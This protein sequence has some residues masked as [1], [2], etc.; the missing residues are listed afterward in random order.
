MPTIKRPSRVDATLVK[1]FEEAIAGRGDGRVSAS[2]VKELIAPAFR[3]S[4]GANWQGEEP[5][6]LTETEKA[7]LTWAMT[8]FKLTG[9]ARRVL[10]EEL[11]ALTGGPV[12]EWQRN[13]N[14][15]TDVR[16]G[17]ELTQKELDTRAAASF[18]ANTR[19]F[20]WEWGDAVFA[21]PESGNSGTH[22]SALSGDDAARQVLFMAAVNN[23]PTINDRFSPDT[24]AI[25]SVYESDDEEHFGAIFVDK[26]TGEATP[27][28]AYNIVD[29]TYD[30][31][32]AQFEEVFGKAIRDDGTPVSDDDFEDWTYDADI[33]DKIPGRDGR[34]VALDNFSAA[35]EARRDGPLRDAFRPLYDA[36]KAADGPREGAY[37]IGT[38]GKVGD[39]DERMSGVIEAIHMADWRDREVDGS[40]VNVLKPFGKVD[41]DAR[42]GMAA[43]V[44][45]VVGQGGKAMVDDILA[46]LGQRRDLKVA[47]IEV[48]VA[49]R[50]PDTRQYTEQQTVNAHVVINTE[51]GD[52]F[53][54]YDRARL[55]D[56]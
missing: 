20:A 40:D 55:A 38:L 5:G 15:P 13:V 21:H 45:A 52:W 32:R 7:T 39:L 28:E 47:E 8:A 17:G 33:W 46:N 31:S 29:L 49:L 22:L 6:R 35:Q 50:D 3:D 37:D 36:F 10:S 27:V 51:E 48:D 12:F 1:R 34:P 23:D 41:A 14:G 43:T 4:W 42:A 24:H 18:A 2:D 11:I 9:A 26:K 19:A 56:D 53:V 30:L 44:D 54:L 16:L 25:Y